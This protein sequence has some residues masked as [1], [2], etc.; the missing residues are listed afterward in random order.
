L[1]IVEAWQVA[2]RRI[3]V[4]EERVLGAAAASATL[5]PTATIKDRNKTKRGTTKQRTELKVN[6][7]FTPAF[8]E[9]C[10]NHMN[11]RARPAGY[12]SIAEYACND[13]T[14]MSNGKTWRDNLPADQQS[15]EALRFMDKVYAT[16]GVVKEKWN[17]KTSVKSNGHNNFICTLA[18]AK[19][20]KS[21][22]Q[23]CRSLKTP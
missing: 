6:E 3:A 21:Y 4:H 23:L 9:K 5:I 11:K 16:G 20:E 7:D 12:R 2:S 13:H 10:K 8:Y 1:D 19:Q 18:M 14:L 22:R 17:L 15:L